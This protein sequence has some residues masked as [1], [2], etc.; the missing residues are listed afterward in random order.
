MDMAAPVFY[1]ADMIRALPDDGNRYE[2][3]RGELLV[4]PAPRTWHET[5]VLRLT[6]ALDAYLRTHPVGQVFGSRSDISW[7]PDTLVQPDVFVATLD[8]VRTLDWTRV[9]TLLLVV[10][11]LS[12]SSRRAD[13]FTKRIEYQ[14]Q[15]IPLYWIIDPDERSVEI[16]TPEQALPSVERER[17]LWHPAGAAEPFVLALDELLR[18]I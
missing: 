8:E 11:V 3:V 14:R 16:W 12:P 17:L 13:R 2:V 9:K 5:I 4:T 10:E 7:T 15:N 18:P 6:A 1:T